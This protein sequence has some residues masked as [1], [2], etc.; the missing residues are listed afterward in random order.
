M[1]YAEKLQ[2]YCSFCFVFFF[3]PKELKSKKH[4]AECPLGSI[5]IST[6][7]MLFLA[8][9]AWRQSWEGI[10]E[11]GHTRWLEECSKLP[12]PN[13]SPSRLF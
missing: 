7:K 4:G 8:P 13:P 10:E 11:L 5:A 12:K 1:T 3:M 2:A 6:E 9:R